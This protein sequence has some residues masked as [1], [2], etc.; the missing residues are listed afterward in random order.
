MHVFLLLTSLIHALVC[1]TKSRQIRFVIRRARSAH[2]KPQACQAKLLP[3]GSSS[4][5]LR[6]SIYSNTPKKKFIR[7]KNIFTTRK[8]Q[9]RMLYLPPTHLIRIMHAVERYR[10]GGRS[11]EGSEKLQAPP[12]FTDDAI[13][14]E[15]IDSL[16]KTDSSNWWPSISEMF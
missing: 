8:N 14:S 15:V 13:F 3:T 2:G 12:K 10:A 11:A 4:S 16:F 7:I 6:N 1:S 9:G 5:E